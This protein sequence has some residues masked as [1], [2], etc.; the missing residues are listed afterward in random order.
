MEVPL[1]LT[2]PEGDTGLE[3]TVYFL[4]LGEFHV[5]CILQ[6]ACLVLTDYH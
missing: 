1:W 5:L 6:C 3:C 2:W 4:P